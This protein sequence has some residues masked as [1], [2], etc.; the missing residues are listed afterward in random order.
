MVE[1][2]TLDDHMITFRD[3]VDFT[4]WRELAG[5]HFAAPPVVEHLE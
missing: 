3:S 4:R 5:P 1:W 2:N